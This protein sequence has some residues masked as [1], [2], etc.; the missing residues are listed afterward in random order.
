MGRVKE[1]AER[2]VMTIGMTNGNGGAIYTVTGA[3]SQNHLSGLDENYSE[4]AAAIIKQ[5]AV[6]YEAALRALFKRPTGLNRARLQAKKE[7]LEDFFHSPWYE[8]LTDIDG[9]R[10]IAA[11]RQR[12]VEKEKAA[13]RRKL[14]KK[15]KKMSH[16]QGNGG[17]T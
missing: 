13:I 17:L 15:L 12:A 6:D 8:L 7:D 1:T 3:S 11:V 5:A 2:M 16:T 10:L 14:E 4:L 9:D